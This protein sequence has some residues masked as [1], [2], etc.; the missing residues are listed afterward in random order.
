MIPRA[1]ARMKVDDV[2]DGN[3]FLTFLEKT[4]PDSTSRSSSG[5]IRKSFM[6]RIVCYLKG[7]LAADKKFRFYMRK[8]G[9][10]LMDIPE[11]SLHDVLVVPMKKTQKVR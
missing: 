4:Y 7:K 10:K 9:F 5:V 1:L 2:K 6:E 11:L 8:N 3:R